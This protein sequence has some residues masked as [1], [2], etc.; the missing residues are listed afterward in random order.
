M[1]YTEKEK[2]R[3]LARVRRVKGQ[4]NALETALEEGTE[5]SSVLQQI[6]AIRGA[7]T[8]VMR[9]VLE[10]HVR[11]TFGSAAELPAGQ[12]DE[13]VDDLNDLIRSYLK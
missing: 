8:G 12:R 7:V 10:A 11:E 2:K 3:V 1:P 13:A 6:A 9:Q 4:L 5:C